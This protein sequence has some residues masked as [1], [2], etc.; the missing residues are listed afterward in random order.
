M[1][2]RT[3]V[4]SVNAGSMADIAFLLLIFFL[5]TTS[6]ETDTGLDRLL[7]RLEPGP[8]KDVNDRNILLVT[9]N[10]DNELLVDDEQIELSQLKHT[11][12][13]FLDNGGVMEKCRYCQGPRLNYGSDNP[14]DAVVLLKSDRATSYGTYIVVQNELVAAYSILRNREAQRLF[15]QDYN[16]L[17]A[18]YNDPSTTVPERNRLKSKIKQIQALYPLNLIEQ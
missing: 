7:P 2:T 13:T 18:A 11:T 17:E 9:I 10:K 15:D 5:V 4:P 3:A 16:S 1:G 6:I 8:I 14:Q 12:A